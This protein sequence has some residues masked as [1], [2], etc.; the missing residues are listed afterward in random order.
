VASIAGVAGDISDGLRER[1]R[2][3]DLDP[4][5]MFALGHGPWEV[6]LL[7]RHR[8]GRRA[9]LV[10]LY[11]LE[12]ASRGIRPECLSTADRSRLRAAARPVCYPGRRPALPGSDRLGDPHEIS[13]Y[14]PTWLVTFAGWRARLAAALGRAATRIDHVGSTAVPGLAAKPVI[15]IMISVP[16]TRDEPSFLPACF[17]TGVILRMRE[18]RHLL[19]WP[20]PANPREVHL[21]VCESGSDW[22]RDELLF[23][24]Y[25]MADSAVR[26]RY[27]L[28]K[29]DL[30]ARWHDDRRA[31]TEAKT[32]FVLDTL[33]HARMWAID[34][35]W[36]P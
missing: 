14:D 10:D 17:S 34:S 6:W 33:D 8:W 1:L 22:G 3:A 15:D 16:D 27:S 31:Y 5:S 21:H 32:A 35:G 26:D 19:L 4:L 13:E 12:A 18:E 11:E 24:D 23:R 25:L 20:P 28:L 36:N 9:T 7:L 30:I 2:T 29:R